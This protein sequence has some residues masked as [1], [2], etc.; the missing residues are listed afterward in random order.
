MRT[1]NSDSA[2]RSSA[3]PQC[4]SWEKSLI[5]TEIGLRHVF[6]LTLLF[7]SAFARSYIALAETP[8]RGPCEYRDVSDHWLHP[9]FFQQP[10]KFV[11]LRERRMASP[12]PFTSAWIVPTDILWLSLS[13]AAL[14][15]L[16]LIGSSIYE[17]FLGPLSKFPGPKLW[18]L[19]HIPRL[20]AQAAGV[21][22]QVHAKLHQEYG[23]VVR[24]GP[25][26]LSF[27]NGAQAWRDIYG[28]R[29]HGQ[30]QP[31]KEKIFY[32]NP[33]E[34]V[35]SILGADDVNHAR[36]RRILSYAFSDKAL[37]DQEPLLKRWM[38]LMS[39]KLGEHANGMDQVDVLKVYNCTTFDIM[40]TKVRTLARETI[41]CY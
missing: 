16:Y 32:V 24:I 12:H 1:C 40:G 15:V 21:E 34:G 28:F 14:C 23:N 4:R 8:N 41:R 22:S 3:G 38:E 10:V 31:Y 18:A 13:F 11:T 35:P 39:K 19:T 30:P 6:Q 36:T 25:R 17:V 29:K 2:S 26:E 37:K 7:V 33:S 5:C 20:R 9:L 27:A